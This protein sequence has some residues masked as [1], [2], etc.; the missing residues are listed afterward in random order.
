LSLKEGQTV[1]YHFVGSTANSGFYS[2]LIHRL[3]LVLS[4]DPHD[5]EIEQALTKPDLSLQKQL[6]KKSLATWRGSG[7]EMLLVIDGVNE[8]SVDYLLYLTSLANF[9]YRSTVKV[10]LS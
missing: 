4:P 1:F 8:V 6:L 5:P 2:H 9:C 10:S 3:L 7:N